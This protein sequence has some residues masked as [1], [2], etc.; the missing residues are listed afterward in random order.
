MI[1]VSNILRSTSQRVK[2]CIVPKDIGREFPKFKG[3][4]FRNLKAPKTFGKSTMYSLTYE[5]ISPEIVLA[6]HRCVPSENNLRLFSIGAKQ[7]SRLVAQPEER[8]A[9]RTQ[10]SAL[11][12]CD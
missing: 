8:I 10:K 5:T 3:T 1:D 7:S 12:W 2:L 9:N 4:E 11:R 6:M